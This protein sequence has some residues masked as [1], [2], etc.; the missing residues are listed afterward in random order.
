MQA[1]GHEF[2][3][4]RLQVGSSERTSGQVGNFVEIPGQDSEF[5]HMVFGVNKITVKRNLHARTLKTEYRKKRE[6]RKVVGNEHVRS[7]NERT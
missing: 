7:K 6:P 1:G 4:R 2:E 3:S 5:I